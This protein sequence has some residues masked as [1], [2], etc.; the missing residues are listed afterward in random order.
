MEADELSHFRWF[1]RAGQ[2][3]RVTGADDDD[4]ADPGQVVGRTGPNS[5][6]ATAS[7]RLRTSARPLSSSLQAAITS[8]AAPGSVCR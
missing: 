5:P 1:V 6:A 8:H 2:D 7:S 3:S 4:I